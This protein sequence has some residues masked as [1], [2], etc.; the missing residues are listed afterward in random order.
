MA[1]GCWGAGK[2]PDPRHAVLRGERGGVLRREVALASH[3]QVLTCTTAG[4]RAVACFRPARR[5]VRVRKGGP[6]LIAGVPLHAKCYWGEE[7]ACTASF[8]FP[9]KHMRAGS[10]P[11]S[12]APVAEV[13]GS[14]KVLGGR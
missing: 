4:R 5:E 9:R 13:A 3:L 6:A 10:G 12:P 14:A 1:L 11:L 2:T 7:E 8:I